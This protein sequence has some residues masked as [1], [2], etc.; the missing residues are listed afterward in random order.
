MEKSSIKDQ[1]IKGFYAFF[2][3]FLWKLKARNLS[4]E[5]RENSK[6]IDEEFPLEIQ[7]KIEEI[8]IYK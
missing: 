4:K 1:R 3:E 2:E 6:K 5:I 8:G 7:K